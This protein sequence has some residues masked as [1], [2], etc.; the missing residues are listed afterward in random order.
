[1]DY[2]TK[3]TIDGIQPSLSHS[4]INHQVTDGQTSIIPTG[5]I[6]EST[7]PITPTLE[8]KR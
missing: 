1:M 5:S 6:V 7:T 8:F 4:R 3:T 2:G